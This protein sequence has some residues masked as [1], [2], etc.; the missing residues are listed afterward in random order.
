VEPEDLDR[1]EVSYQLAQ[2]VVEV[3]LT[4]KAPVRIPL[5]FFTTVSDPGDPRSSTYRP[6]AKFRKTL[7][8][9]W[10]LETVLSRFEPFSITNRIQ[11]LMITPRR[12]C[13]RELEGSKIESLS[14][15]KCFPF[16]TSK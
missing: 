12:P 6:E 13:W 3:E 1:D 8:N 10:G 9:G 14:T 11:G 4:Q 5:L 7:K 16:W 15:G 2:E